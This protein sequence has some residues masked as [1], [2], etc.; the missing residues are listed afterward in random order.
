MKAGVLKIGAMWF[1]YQFQMNQFE[2]G[3]IWGKLECGEDHTK[4]MS[5]IA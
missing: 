5:G 4:D 3:K 2:I 1:A